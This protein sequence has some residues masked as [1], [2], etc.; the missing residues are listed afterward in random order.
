MCS[1]REECKEIIDECTFSK[2][3]TNKFGEKYQDKTVRDDE[4]AVLRKSH[5]LLAKVKAVLPD[6]TGINP[7]IRVSKFKS[8]ARCMP[9]QDAPFKTSKYNRPRVLEHAARRWRDAVPLQDAAHG[10][11]AACGR[12]V[13]FEQRYRA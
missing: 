3:L 13:I 10:H 8:G 2:E 5:G 11:P 1:P 6:A 4:G 9:H 12:M 7:L